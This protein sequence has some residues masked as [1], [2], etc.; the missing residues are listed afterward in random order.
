MSGTFVIAEAGVNHN[1]SIERALEMVDVAARAGADAVKFQTFR[2]E[3]LVTPGAVK[4]AY[5]QAG[6]GSEDGQFAMLKQLELSEGDYLCLADACKRAG[7]EFMSTAF[8][9]E[10]LRFLIESAG[11]S[12]VKI[13][14]GEI[15][16][17]QLLI[18]AG[19]SGLPVLLSTGMATL[20]EIEDALDVLAFGRMPDAPSL[21][22]STLKGIYRGSELERTVTIL[23][24]T[25]V[26]PA[27]ATDINLRAMDTFTTAFGLP[28]GFSDHS[29]GIAISLA[30]VGRGATVIE[31]HFTLDR[32][33]P[34]P[35][36]SASLEPVD[37]AKM[38]SGIRLVE[39][40]LGSGQ[41]VCLESEA[42][43]AIVARRGVYAARD[44]AAGEPLELADMILLRPENGLSPMRL[45]DLVGTK[46]RRAYRKLEALDR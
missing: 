33:L 20:A 35:D 32:G 38:I 6:T 24:C 12:R 29:S 40:A 37:L 44:I 45:W 3:S 9:T 19:R 16:N 14:S 10:S 31:K 8:D 30:A 42:Q 26:Y 25:T 4:A 46:A 22:T 34:G 21:R 2:A 15:T 17:P 39:Q 1:G 36:H 43:N 23:Q 13:P 28:V 11:I 27:P 7:I 41:K 5:Q 18:A